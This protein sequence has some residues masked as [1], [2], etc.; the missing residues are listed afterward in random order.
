[1]S[2]DI[3]KLERSIPKYELELEII[4]IISKPGKKYFDKLYDEITTL[5]KIIQQSNFLLTRSMEK[6]VLNRYADLLS[7]NKE[8]MKK[9]DARKPQSL[10]IQHVVELLP[11]NYAITDKADGERYFLIIYNNV[12]YL[13]DNNLHIKNSG[14]IISKSLKYND[15]ILDGE[16]I[17]IRKH[18]RYI[19]MVFDCLYKSGKD[20]RKEQYFMERLKHADEV[21]EKCFILKGQKGYKMKEYVGKYKPSNIIAFHNK[22]IDS[23]MDALNK[24]IMHEKK[25]PLIRRKYF[26]GVN[27]SQDNEIF[28]YSELMWNKYV[29]DKNTNCPYILDGLIYHPLN[30]K[31]I[32]SVKES[33][34]FEYKWK[35]PNKNSIDFYVL[36]DR[37]MEGRI[38]N[39]YDNSED[40]S[41]KGKAYRIVNLYVGRSISGIEK[42]VL[43]QRNKNKYYAY[44]FLSDGEVRDIEENNI[45]QDGTVVEFYYNNDPNIPQ[46]FRWV[47]M[48]TRHDKTEIV[49]RYKKS[50]GN[51]VT[52]ANKI[53]RSISNP[54]L[55]SDVSILAN[56]STYRKQIDI[57]RGKID[58]SIIMSS[59]KED[60][61]YQMKTTLAKPMRNFHNWLKS[62][63][64][65]TYCNPEYNK[66]ESVSVLDIACGRG[67]DL[68]KFYYSKV[69][70]YVGIDIDNNGL[71][72]PTD[73][74]VS[75]YNKMKRSYPNFPNMSFI[76]ADAGV[77][78][79]YDEQIKALGSMTSTNKKLMNKYFSVNENKRTIFD[80]I[81]CQFAIHYM[82]KNKIIWNNFLK[83][84]KMYLRPG[85][86]MMITTFDADK[87][88]KILEKKDQYKSYY[89][90]TKGTKKIFFDIIKKYG[91]IKRDMVGLGH[92]IDVHTSIIFQ[93][94]VHVT[95]YLV[96]KRFLEKEFLE[97]CDME[98]VETDLFENQFHI[99]KKYMKHI[100]KYEENPKTRK[101][102]MNVAKY[103]DQV[104]EVNRACYKMTRL[105]RYYIF[106]R[107]D[108]GS[109]KKQKGGYINDYPRFTGDNV[110]EFVFNKAEHLLNPTKFIHRQINSLEDHSFFSSVH[111]ILQTSDIIPNTVDAKNF[112]DDIGYKLIKD[113]DI[114]KKDISNLCKS[115]VI[116]HEYSDDNTPSG[117]DGV[118]ILVL[119]D[120][121]EFNVILYSKTTRLRKECSTMLLYKNNGIYRPIYRHKNN[122]YDGLF[123]TRLKFIKKIVNNS[124]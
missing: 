14:I 34:F 44:L 19:F 51:Y 38:T 102:L 33:K 118:N 16:Y 28:K 95:E 115:L 72:S 66:N 43:F 9:L 110:D 109:Q 114:T 3:N 103:Y 85:G 39:V 76:H 10:E 81:N 116:G 45:I 93:E 37:S 15:T 82:L 2:K 104:D 113:G 112:Y 52:V 47:P 4:S 46:E 70:F 53:W 120:T 101:F 62:I 78:L 91:E 32:V 11:N 86:Y 84:I 107:K 29:L 77:I 7:V 26:I 58:H 8:K 25:Y 83:N 6:E 24:D 67:G 100:I 35:P 111:D 89:T 69:K 79:D 5:L 42:P 74:A 60:I 41:I 94:G 123:N 21:I 64:I 119:D 22:K 80:R 36:F 121:N 117:L 56:D 23:Y 59:R 27:G 18:N 122:K 99:H 73:G 30:Q 106:R 90:D 65:Y 75:R 68:M 63:I 98:L 54:F 96:D 61:Y 71:I 12:A 105:Y 108:Q 88:R 48:R 124:K 97:K 40:K 31:Y 20:I 13:I 17:R 57:L 1:M 50:Y 49:M 55:M 87:V 92:A